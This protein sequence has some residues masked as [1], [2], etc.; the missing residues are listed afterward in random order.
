MR[1]KLSL[2]TTSIHAGHARGVFVPAVS[3]PTF[4]I[5]QHNDM[6]RTSN[7]FGFTLVELLV[8]ITIIG[9]LIALLLP[10]VQ[11][12]R[13]AARMSQC[14]NSIKQFAVGCFNHETLTKRYPSGG[15]NWAWTG[16]ADMGNDWLQPGGWIYNVLPFMEQQA[17]H[18]MGA[19]AGTW[20]S[21]AKKDAHRNRMAATIPGINCPS[22]R[23]SGAFPASFY[24][25]GSNYSS[26]SQVTRSDYAANGG[27]TYQ[28]LPRNITSPDDALSMRQDF[29]NLAK[30]V[31][32][33]M[34][35][36]SM[37]STADISDGTSNTYL[38][39][40][41]YLCP[42]CYETPDPYAW[43]DN[44][45]SLIG[46]D[47]DV[48]RWATGQPW[49]DTPSYFSGGCEQLFGSA[50]SNGF[51]IAFCDGSVQTIN[52]SIDLPTHQRLANRQD[53]QTIDTKK[54]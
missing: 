1:R 47:H 54:L 38:L 46:D 5:S 42:D 7:R 32:G 9:I 14:K 43:G 28:E 36:G 4:Y 2:S 24:G 6:K 50:H 44:E 49:P 25:T 52:Y 11:S 33:I 26:P 12:A 53:G 22:R 13:E 34:F 17:L 29:A 16:D 40:E 19:G 41:K 10:A 39:G 21:T 27:D 35:A 31:N 3:V 48:T 15:W 23:K 30:A 45:A 8:V 51:N 37:I 20:D 18:D